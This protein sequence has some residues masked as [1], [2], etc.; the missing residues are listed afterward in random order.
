MLLIKNETSGSPF[1]SIIIIKIALKN[2]GQRQGY[3]VAIHP[4]IYM[5][6][7]GD[8][9]LEASRFC[10]ILR[11]ASNYCVELF[12]SGDGWAWQLSFSQLLLLCTD[13]IDFCLPTVPMNSTATFNALIDA[14]FIRL[15]DDHVGS[16]PAKS[17]TPRITITGTPGDVVVCWINKVIHS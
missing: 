6:I 4:N 2:H 14:R 13:S 1:C 7:W 11:V 9:G 17:D 3:N 10:I 5:F 15:V 12:W 8:T 16:P